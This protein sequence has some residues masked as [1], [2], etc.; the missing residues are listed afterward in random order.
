MYIPVVPKTNRREWPHSSF[1]A[2]SSQDPF[3]ECD[4]SADPC[5]AVGEEELKLSSVAAGDSDT[6]LSGLNL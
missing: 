4:S 5:P 2:L 1:L 3:P 6:C